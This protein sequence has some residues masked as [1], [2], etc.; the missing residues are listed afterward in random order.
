MAARPRRAR[1]REE[2]MIG[3]KE[4]GRGARGRGGERERGREREQE[5][6]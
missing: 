1:E 6:R 4:I 5:A 2:S 3:W